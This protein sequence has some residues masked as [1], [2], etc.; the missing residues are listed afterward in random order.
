M[1]VYRLSPPTDGTALAVALCLTVVPWLAACGGPVWPFGSAGEITTQERDVTGATGVQ[2]ATSG[3][4]VIAEGPSPSLT[5]TAGENVID[6][7]TSDVSGTVVRLGT[8]GSGSVGTIEYRLVVT[9]LDS[10]EIAGSGDAEAGA[11][12]ADG[13]EVI[14]AGSGGVDVQGV[15]VDEVEVRISGSGGVELAG[16]ATRQ[17]VV[18]EGSGSYSGGS[19][20]TEQAS[21]EVAGSGN[22]AVD[23][24]DEL[25]VRITG[26]G[27]V[28]YLGDPEVDSVVA[29]SGGVSR[30]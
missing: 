25:T 8:S 13:L 6:R 23:V 7:L 12:T 3:H 30:G 10:L 19:L 14:I 11:A 2:L 21:V 9:E 29:G 28:S 5:I 20:T 1:R 18:I 22:V 26:S 27:D 16:R 15:D 4:L 17:Q 24:T